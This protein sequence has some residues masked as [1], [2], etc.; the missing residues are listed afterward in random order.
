MNQNGFSLVELVTTIGI[1]SILLAIATLNYNNWQVKY[2]VENQVKVMHSDINSLRLRAIHTKKL[3]RIEL[4]SGGYVFKRSSSDE[5]VY[6]SGPIV[7]SKTVTY[8]LMKADGTSINGENI[9][10]NSRGFTSNNL[11][12]RIDSPTNNAAQDCLIV[13]AAQTNLGKM[14]N[15]TC[16]PK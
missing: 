1:I 7:E 13:S 8:P 4:Q 3:H 16:T 10:F 6:V 2:N 12:I 11:T 9:D 15:G 5:D 14:E